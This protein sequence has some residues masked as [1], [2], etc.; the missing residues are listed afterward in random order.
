VKPL[1]H[2]SN[3][4]P[5]RLRAAAAVPLLVSLLPSVGFSFGTTRLPGAARVPICSAD[6]LALTIP[7]AGPKTSATV[8]QGAVFALW[9]TNRG[10]IC[11]VKGYPR[12]SALVS[13]GGKKLNFNQLDSTRT[14]AGGPY[15][16]IAVILSRGSSA[17]SLV[18]Y[19]GGNLPAPCAK[20]LIV[21]PISG[22]RNVH[23]EVRRSPQICPG[24]YRTHELQVTPYHPASVGP[25]SHWP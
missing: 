21:Q 12:L 14:V 19:A 5:S 10:Q 9:V 7:P 2:S 15:E 3:D 23:L 17:A 18:A 13:A 20:W 8:M 24:S 4:H 11:S 25:F 22:A 6:Q 1:Q 16:S